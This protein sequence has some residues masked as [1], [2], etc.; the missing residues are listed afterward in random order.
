V[1]EAIPRGVKAIYVSPSHQ[2]PLGTS[3]SLRRRLALLA[4]AH[5]HDAAILEDDYDS[6]FRF[7]GRPIEPLQ[8]L[9]T[10]GRVIYIGSFSKTM[11]PTLRLGFAIVPPSIR[12]AVRT[13]KFLTD[14]HSALPTQAALASFIESGMFA[15][16]V[17]R[18]RKVYYA[19]H[20][21]VTRVLKRSFARD[22]RLV[23]SSVGLHVSAVASLASVDEIAAIVRR[24]SAIG[25]E[26][27]PLSMFAVGDSPRAGL[28]LGYGAIDTA[29][30]EVG[31][32]R[33]R[34][35]FGS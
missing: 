24:A 1:V 19:R 13:A 17:R 29:G 15:R 28:V 33:L 11:L 23:P 16:H 30:I 4:W 32:D 9:D 25:V 34:G 26:C 18:M 21:L 8:M 27:Q 10:T 5:S 12:E 22:L 7:G 2:F 35:C 20:E 31:L 6:E 3:M 14:W